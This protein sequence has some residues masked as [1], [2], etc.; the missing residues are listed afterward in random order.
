[1]RIIYNVYFH[2]LSRFPGPPGA[3]STKLWLAYMEV[4]KGV[5]LTELRFQLHDKYG[6]IIRIAPDEL[7]FSNPSVYNEIYNL[8]NKWDKDHRLYRAT[9]LDSF[10]G[11]PRYP[12]VE[13]RR[14]VFNPLFSKSAILK[15]QHLFYERL[16][17]FCDALRAQNLA[18][19]SSNLSL[20]FKCFSA[21]ATSLYCFG[22]CFDQTLL[23]DFNAP[24]LVAMEQSLP[25]FSLRKHF[26]VIVWVVRNFS[27]HP[28]MSIFPSTIRSLCLLYKIL[29]SQAK[30]IICDPQ[31]LEKAP[32]SNILPKLLNHEVTNRRPVITTKHILRESQVL[33]CAWS[34]HVIGTALM[35]GTYHIL[36]NQEMR[37]RLLGELLTVWPDLNQPP[38]YDTLERLPYLT[39]VVK[40][41]LRLTPTTPVG[42]ARVVPCEGAT[43][44]GVRIPGGVRVYQS[45]LFVHLSEDIFVCASDFMPE[46]WL[47]PDAAKL[48]RFLVAFSD[49]P[50]SC[51]GI[52]LAYCEMYLAFAHL[53]RR[54]DFRIDEKRPASLAWKEHFLPYYIG[55]HLHVFCSPRPS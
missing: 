22:A 10:F 23:R 26:N 15:T 21:D 18:G 44:S 36:H 12:E 1:M 11:S 9:D 20:G 7:H 30:K 37:E 51:Q 49:G 46:R 34:S 13:L 43:I 8:N 6:E 28:L 5:D 4:W 41:T 19:K 52:N 53:F 39:A 45:S 16:D 17:V 54:F 50:R 47:R 48:N 24:L 35:T 27:D 40:E 55:E 3:A 38:R 31:Q 2:P 32:P 33:F 25:S 42:L 14:A 29:D